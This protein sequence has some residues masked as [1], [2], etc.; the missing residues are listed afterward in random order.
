MLFCQDSTQNFP[1]KNISININSYDLI[2][3]FTITQNYI[4]DS[5]KTL[6][7]YY[8]FPTPANACVFEFK[9][10]FGEK[11]IFSII[12]EK[13]EAIREYNQSILQ[14]DNPFLME[15]IDGNIFTCCIG[16]VLPKS[17]ITI[18]IKYV[19]ELKTEIDCSNIR[20]NVPMTIMPK[21]VPHQMKLDS[22]QIQNAITV[23]DKPCSINIFGDINISDGIIAIDSKISKINLTKIK[24]FNIG[25][26]IIDLENIN[27]DIIISIKKNKSKT[28]A[29]TQE[30]NTC[31]AN[32]KYATMINLR[33]N[34]DSVPQID[35][36]NVHYCLILDRSGSMA[37]N[38]L[39]NCKKS[40]KIFI[41]L[42]PNGST[43][44]IYHFGSDFVKFKYEQVENNNDEFMKIKRQA[45]EWI[46]TIK[47]DGGTE[48]IEVL[49]DC[50]ESIKQFKKTGVIIFIS[51]GA[52]SN[53]N[54][55][56]SLVK[57]NPETNIFTIGIGQSV[58]Q[59]LI[60]E[61]ANQGNGKSEFI[62]NGS[63]NIEKKVISQL[64]R[65]YKSLRK[66]I[67]ENILDIEIDGQY[68]MIPDKLPILY[69]N[70]DNLIMIISENPLKS[71]TY[72]YNINTY[73]IR[74]NVPI[75]IIQDENYPIHRIAGNK[76]I[77]NLLNNEGTKIDHL[78]DELKKQIISLSKILN[79]L[80]PYTSFIGVNIVEDKIKNESKLIEIPLQIIK[81][82]AYSDSV[83]LSFSGLGERYNTRKKW[84]G[85]YNPKNLSTDNI[86]QF[87]C[88]TYY[89][90]NNLFD[91][92]TN[93]PG[94][95]LRNC[96][97]NNGSSAEYKRGHAFDMKD[98]S[99]T[100][101]FGDKNCDYGKPKSQG[102]IDTRLGITDTV[103]NKREFYTHAKPSRSIRSESNLIDQYY[104]DLKINKSEIVY[105]FTTEL[106]PNILI[107]NLLISNNNEILNLPEEVKVDNYIQ[108]L[109]NEFVYKIISL[110]SNDT[111]WVLEKVGIIA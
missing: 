53:T 8:K 103:Y 54:E 90:K 70:D 65:A 79:I 31:D 32:L 33:P 93:L 78:R 110:G 20:I 85:Q 67:N 26:E 91:L 29:I 48:I 89:D 71:I 34:F 73:D 74:Y 50:Y 69:E 47:S 82:S 108:L 41:S 92:N 61:M 58:S 111:P 19:I 38:D 49:K 86:M 30:W 102:L 3:L 11:E 83:T 12:K 56:I 94:P 21:Y 64:N 97:E 28:N 95:T 76:F 55:I 43:F 105:S 109:N 77:N 68:K 87:H 24:E 4:N 100:N 72:K 16:N 60:Q 59:Q 18:T 62:N 101:F 13:N 46:D 17:E 45:I 81:K 25:F 40:A 51:D 42:L 37:G 107:S 88:S 35:I 44:D 22:E 5:D 15:E 39:E 1:L 9:A 6:E 10:K 98:Q 84:L 23:S 106:P 14:G 80:C 7:T 66:N 27:E 36:K 75:Q 63:D 99:K 104:P 52:V 2:G 96:V 57:K